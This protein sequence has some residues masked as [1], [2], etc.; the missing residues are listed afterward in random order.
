MLHI[1][2]YTK[3]SWIT[4]RNTGLGQICYQGKTFIKVKFKGEAT[5]VHCDK[6]KPRETLALHL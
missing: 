3:I 2:E 4:L 5:G 6:A 1:K